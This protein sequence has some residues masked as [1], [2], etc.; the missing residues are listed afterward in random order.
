MD[1][2]NKAVNKTDYIVCYKCGGRKF[3]SSR[4]II[5]LLVTIPSI[6]ILDKIIVSMFPGLFA[7]MI[8]SVILI[9]VIIKIGKNIIKC[10]VCDGSGVIKTLNGSPVRVSQ[11]QL[12]KKPLNWV[13]L[14]VVI[15]AIA[16]KGPIFGFIE[17][18]GSNSNDSMRIYETET[19]AKAIVKDQLGSNIRW[20]HVDYIDSDDYGRHIV[21]AIFKAK[22]EYGYEMKYYTFVTI[23]NITDDKYRYSR[24][25]AITDYENDYLYDFGLELAKTTN[26]WNE[27]K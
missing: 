12:E 1:D 16:F 2:T 25:Y 22:N 18:L 17:G 3:I 15:L 26:N 13:I 5:L 10:E 8:I 21:Q 23:Q 4:L 24:L 19:A 11:E 9:S 27:Q 6:I 7:K 14:I 20:I